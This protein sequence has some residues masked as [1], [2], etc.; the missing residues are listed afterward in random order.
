MNDTKD[1][2]KMKNPRAA[3]K[4]ENEEADEEQEKR[5]RSWRRGE[6]SLLYPV[7]AI[8]MIKTKTESNNSRTLH[9]SK[10]KSS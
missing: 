8:K 2:D 7:R 3:E 5:R 10:S 1:A 6:A 4:D 9:K